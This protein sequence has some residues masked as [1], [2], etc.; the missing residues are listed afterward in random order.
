MPLNKSWPPDYI[1][2]VIERSERL[3]GLR[4]DNSLIPP[5]KA[6]Y[7]LHPARFI[8]DWCITY[9][10][11]KAN[12]DRPARMPFILFDRQRDLVSFLQDCMKSQESGLI[13][14]SR[15][16]GATWVCTAF[17]VYLWLFSDGASVGW[18][19][20]KEM[21]VDRIG[22]PD[23]IFEKIRMQINSLPPF[24]LPAGFDWRAHGAYMKIINPENGNTI[25]GEAGDNI[26]R[27]GRKS[28]YFKDESAH[29]EHPESIEAALGDN[30]NVQIDLSSVN[31]T[32]NVFHR[33]RQTGAVWEIGRDIEKGRTRIFLFDWREHPEKNQAWY[34]QRRAKAE[35]EG[36]LHLFAQEVD[37]DY[38]ASV[39]NLVIPA[40]WIKAAIDAHK[41][42]GIDVTGQTVGSLDVADEG[43][44]K[45]ALAIV[46][47]IV[48]VYCEHWAEGDT[49]NT[50]RK[51]V[52]ICKQHGCN[53]LQYDCVGVG[54]GVKA[55]TNRLR[56]DG[57]IKSNFDIVPWNGG[58]SV[59]LPTSRIIESDRG[60][61]KN[62]DFYANLKA[63]AYWQ[64]RLRFEK[65]YK[66]IVKGQK[67]PHDQLISIDSTIPYLSEL[68]DELSQP[69]F[70]YDTRGKI[71][72]NK[73]PDG[74][75]SPNL[76]DAIKTAFWPI[77]KQRVII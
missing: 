36:L 25:T 69:T 72:V 73:Q 7:K 64:L 47:G 5:A 48:L 37:R 31:G 60:T 20:R 50:A 56:A 6:Y 19:S 57:L 16:M 58:D 13:E 27:G 2:H 8:D 65:T 41:I 66:V 51:A 46:K 33:R 12:I 38:A 3:A 10:P 39:N 29:Y 35:R 40:I 52:S 26:G 70:G 17:S 49:G 28:I 9:D 45:N 14:K 34:E 71:L 74:T 43:G 67:F 23:S 44:D 53:N 42:L 15:D 21:L 75:K 22:D 4:D 32:G 77:R 54:A 62:I 76:A 63:Q 1:K 55:E 24:L 30:T 18:G 61:P 68:T 11:R 59:L